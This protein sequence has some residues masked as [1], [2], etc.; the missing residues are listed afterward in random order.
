VRPVTQGTVTAEA[1]V[2]SREGRTL[3]GQATIY[4]ETR[5]PVLEFSSTFKIARDRGVVEVTG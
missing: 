4:D 1:Q 5:A 3:K 2:M